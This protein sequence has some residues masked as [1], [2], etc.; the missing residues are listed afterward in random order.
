MAN[1]E[2]TR[3]KQTKANECMSTEFKAL[4]DRD[5]GYE[6]LENKLQSNG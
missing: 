5:G 4:E 2:E 6:A 1:Q 3:S